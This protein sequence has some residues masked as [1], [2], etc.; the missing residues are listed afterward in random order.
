[1]ASIPT[2]RTP[3]CLR[4]HRW[5]AACTDCGRRAVPAPPAVRVT[6][7]R[8][9]DV[10]AAQR[11][12]IGELTRDGASNRTIG[13]RLFITEDTVKCH[14]R[15]AMKATGCGSRTALAVALLRGQLV[16]RTRAT[17]WA[18]RDVAA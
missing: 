8:I 7:P 16:L 1:M 9:A 6:T 5:M 12:V 10:T 3:V 18:D 15:A 11:A 13:Q 4:H 14:V 2:P 17:N